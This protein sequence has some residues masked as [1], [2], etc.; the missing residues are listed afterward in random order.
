M[1][2]WVRDCADRNLANN[3]ERWRRMQ[4]TYQEA[5]RAFRDAGLEFAVLKGF[6]HCPRFVSDP[7]YRPQGDLDLL[8]R[9]EQVNQAYEV[10]LGLG[11][12]PARPRDS[13]PLNHL[14]T[15]IRKTGWE[16]KGDFFDTEIPVSLELHYQLWQAETERFTPGGLEAFW[17]R[18]EGREVDGV[19]FTGLHPADEVAHAALHVLR[20]LLQGS[21]RPLHVYE[22]A[23]MLHRSADASDF[24][25]TWPELH[26]ASLR[27][28]EAICFALAQRWFDCRMPEAVCDEMERLPAPVDRWVA[29]YGWAPLAARFHPNKDELWLH[30]SL[31]D[32]ASARLTVLRRRLLPEQLPGFVDSAHIPDQQRTW[33]MRVCGYGRSFQYAAARLSHHVRAVPATAGSAVRWFGAG[34]ELGGDYWRFLLAEGFYDFGMFVFFFLYNLYLLRLGFRENFL[35]LMSSIMIGGNF[36][37]SILAV[38]AIERFGLQRTLMASF[39]LTAGI[40]GLRAVVLSSPVLLALAAVAGLISSVWPVALA[41]AV[42][43]VT[44]EKSRA[45]GFSFICSSGIAIGIFGS[46]AAGRLPG[47][48]SHSQGASSSIAPYRAALLA[49][50]SI[51]LLALWPLSRVKMTD[52]PRP[53][54]R[55]FH[56]PSPLLARFLV[57]MLIWNLGTGIFNPFRNVF[58]ARQIHL[59]VEKIGTVFSWSQ[60]LQVGAILLAPAVFRRFGLT[61][62]IAGMQIA[63][64]LTLI[65]LASVTGPVGAALVYCFFMAAQYMSEPGMFTFLMD[66]V[67]AGERNSASALNFLVSYSGQAIA[68]A[69]AGIL[70]ARFGYSPVL[71]GA[72]IICAGAGLLFRGLLGKPPPVSPSPP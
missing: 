27:R 60:V 55:K 8:F 43:S 7:R 19:L 25:S 23:W 68:A 49:G 58:F 10:A 46:L 20:H 36:V 29:E 54:R 52:A 31:L 47:W 22:L 17:D 38:F 41:P 9:E 37:G 12:E 45:R 56:R 11:Y 26:D 4:V 14:P 21:L 71:I 24:W 13:H 44:T 51:V 3:A 30:W 42:A 61:R 67:A 50:C 15:L 65:G 6:S 28:L 5:A 16:W 53:S 1:P 70:L 63:T 40:S 66:S 57:A 48:I 72:A 62:A 35:G 69:A 33:R 64:A 2:D 59:G 32:S 34:L 18:R 39:A